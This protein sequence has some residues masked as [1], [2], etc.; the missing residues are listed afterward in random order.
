MQS[1]ELQATIKIDV[2]QMKERQHAGIRPFPAQVMAD[3]C[4]FQMR[5]QRFC[6]G[7]AKPF[8]EIAQNNARS[9]KARMVDDLIVEQPPRLRAVFKERCAEVDIED[10]QHGGVQLYVGA[11]ASSGFTTPGRDVIVAMNV[12]GKPAEDDIPVTA[13]AKLARFSEGKM[14][15]EFFG[16]KSSL[17]RFAIPPF[18]TQN[19]LQRNDVR[20]NLAQD[21]HNPAWAHTSIQTS[22][23]VN[24]IGYD[25]NCLVGV[26][27][28]F[29]IQQLDINIF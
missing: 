27:T 24:V 9:G 3:I 4:P 22:T 8:I 21:V 23:F 26:L 11:Q 18:D 5:T 29:Q 1:L 12:D 17:I 16:N 14:Q 20:V 13:A 15:A 25:S 10:M 28:Q 6:N 7:A 19:F 2:I